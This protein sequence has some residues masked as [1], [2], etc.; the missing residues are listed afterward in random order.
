VTFYDIPEIIEKPYL[1]K[2]NKYQGFINT[3]GNVAYNYSAPDYVNFR[4]KWNYI[5]DK[6]ENDTLYPNFVI[7][8]PKGPQFPAFNS[9]ICIKSYAYGVKKVS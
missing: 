6:D 9:Y 4:D 7:V 1:P 8:N 3:Y 5:H 2:F